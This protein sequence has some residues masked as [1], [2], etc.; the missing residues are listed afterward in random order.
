MKVRWDFVTNSSSTSFVIICSGKPRLDDFLAAVGAK[1]GTP[2]EELFRQL[3]CVL[4]DGLKP[5]NEADRKES[6]SVYDMLRE[7]FSERTAKRVQSALSEG[8]DVWFGRLAS[9][10]TEVEA[11]FCT[12]SFEIERGDFYLNALPCGW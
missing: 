4:C 2:A 12:D 7:E 5:V 8:K 6:E 3:Y 9:E 10:N 11:F 1:A